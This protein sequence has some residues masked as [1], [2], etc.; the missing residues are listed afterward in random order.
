MIV[1]AVLWLAVALLCFLG[2]K[3]VMYVIGSVAIVISVFYIIM[4]IIVFGM[5]LKEFENESVREDVNL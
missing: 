1:N 3:I 5:D 4:T 2:I